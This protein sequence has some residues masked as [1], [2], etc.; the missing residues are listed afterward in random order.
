MKKLQLLL[1]DANV[2]IMLHELQCWN[3][4]VDRCDIHIAG[5]II[6]LEANYYRDQ[7]NDQCRIDLT[8]QIATGKIMRFEVGLSSV[9]EFIQRFKPSFLDALDPGETES[10]T[11]LVNSDQKYRI[12]SAD[13][14]VYRVLGALNRTHQGRSA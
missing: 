3:E 1:F 13:K 7:N 11:Y 10:L 12:C 4:V 5:T 14:I 9:N 6:D 8:D 2:V